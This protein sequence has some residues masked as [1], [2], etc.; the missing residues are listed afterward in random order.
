MTKQTRPGQRR[1]FETLFRL[2]AT[3]LTLCTLSAALAAPAPSLKGITP[4]VSPFGAVW[5]MGELPDALRTKLAARLSADLKA[6][7]RAQG[8]N[9]RE[10]PECSDTKGYLHLEAYI[11]GMG[12]GSG[13]TRQT[14]FTGWFEDPS[15]SGRYVGG[16]YLWYDYHYD[17][18]GD[19]EDEL[20]ARLQTDMKTTL[21]KFVADWKAAN[22]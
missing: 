14:K 11:E 3:T 10:Q 17:R 21:G 12:T 6:E 19:R 22:R 18:V 8:V 4:C 2:A 1:T 16:K 5:V 13:G 20:L 9:F 7:L 15:K